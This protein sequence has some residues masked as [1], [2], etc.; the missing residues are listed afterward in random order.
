MNFD[1]GALDYR[2][3]FCAFTG[4]FPPSRKSCSQSFIHPAHKRVTQA[5]GRLSLNRITKGKNK[6][7]GALKCDRC[8]C[9]YEKPL[10]YKPKSSLKVSGHSISPIGYEAQHDLCPSCSKELLDWFSRPTRR[11]TDAEDSAPSQA[12]SNADNL[13]N[14]DG[15]AVPTRRS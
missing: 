14:S 15:F 2:Y 5:V 9:L 3:A 12:V 1:L 8:G 11:A 6:M 10:W 7:A 4:I 13:S